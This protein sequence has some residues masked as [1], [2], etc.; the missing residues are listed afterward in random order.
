MARP[1]KRTY[2]NS[3]R[4][5]AALQ[6]RRAVV[7]AARELFLAQ[8]YAATTLAAIADAA[9][10]SVQT[11][12]AQF[13]NK[14]ALVKQVV[15][16]AVAGDDEPVPLNGRPEIL[17]QIAEPDPWVRIGMHARF[18]ASTMP[19]VEPVFRMVALAAAADSGMRAEEQRLTEGRLEGMRE[20]AGLYAGRGEL[21]V[22]LEEAAQRIAALM[23]PELYRRTV[24]DHGWS[25][26]EYAEWL[27]ALMA[28][29]ILPPKPARSRR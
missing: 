26:E 9:G 12:Y 17:A 2:D 15:D 14:P 20:M 7:A 25:I 16:E 10:V 21:A 29:S 19:R 22:P 6:T 13:K 27:A 23:Q 18:V 5:A 8:G 28:A 11:V 4:E 1:V 3:G 24:L